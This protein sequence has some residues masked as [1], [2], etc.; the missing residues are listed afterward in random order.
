LSLSRQRY[1]CIYATALIVAYGLIVQGISVWK[2]RRS[3][4]LARLLPFLLGA[5]IGVSIGVELL[6]WTRSRP[7]IG[8]INTMVFT[9]LPS[10][11]LLIL[12][13]FAPNL[14]TTIALLLARSGL[15]QM[16]VPTRT[17]YV[18]AVVT[19]SERPAAAS[20]T[21]VPKTFAWAAGSMISGW[22]LT[23]SSFGWPL[24]IGGVIN[25]V[26]DILLLIK[27]HKMRPPEEAGAA[28][29]YSSA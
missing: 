24:L 14:A 17:S 26:Y 8:L 12:I 2:L 15:S 6:H 18:M 25:G 23:L 1:G 5:V 22:L 29:D 4:K 21:A 16:D 9:H 10:N 7:R 11:V 13:P 27:F 3:I 28:A 20:I 19:P